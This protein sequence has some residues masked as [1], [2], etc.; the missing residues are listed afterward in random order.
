MQRKFSQLYSE[1]FKNFLLKMGYFLPTKIV[2]FCI[3]IMSVFVNTTAMVV[4]SYI[5]LYMY[6]EVIIC[7]SDR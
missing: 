5:V 2:A 4:N 3:F 7:Q 6:V 1:F